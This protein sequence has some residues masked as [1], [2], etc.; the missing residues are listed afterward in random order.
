[1]IGLMQIMIGLFCIY[2]V[3]KGTEIYQI[4]YMTDEQ[5]PDRRMGLVLGI[6]AILGA[7]F[8]AGTA[9][10]LTVEMSVQ[11]NNVMPPFPR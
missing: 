5:H 8:F 4:A 11:M 2:L 7:I 9:I 1:M 10:Y 6:I 3:Y